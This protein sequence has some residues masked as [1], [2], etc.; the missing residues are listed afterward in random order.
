MC[1]SVLFWHIEE[2]QRTN[3]SQKWC[4]T[5]GCGAR[6]GSGGSPGA[7]VDRA[8]G[9]AGGRVALQVP[10]WNPLLPTSLTEELGSPIICA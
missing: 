8:D 3:L 1:S 6:E 9:P 7:Q 4:L 2:A 5:Q 10:Q